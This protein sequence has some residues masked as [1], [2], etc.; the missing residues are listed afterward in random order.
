MQSVGCGICVMSEFKPYIGSWIIVVA[1]PL[2][3]GE[4][5]AYRNLE[6]NDRNNTDDSGYL[7]VH[8]DKS[9]LWYDEKFFITAFRPLTQEEKRMAVCA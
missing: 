7:V 3:Y 2:T 5:C 1:R 6:P 9:K 8:Q 4:Y